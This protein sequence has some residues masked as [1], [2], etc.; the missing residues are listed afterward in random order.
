M[1]SVLQEQQLKSDSAVNGQ[2]VKLVHPKVLTVTGL[3]KYPLVHC[4]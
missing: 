4:V 3:M 1:G 2:G